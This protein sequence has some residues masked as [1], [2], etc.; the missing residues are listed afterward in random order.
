M[1]FCVAWH[2]HVE[3]IMLIYEPL[4][5]IDRKMKANDW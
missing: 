2:V 5:A 4:I 3:E 1:K